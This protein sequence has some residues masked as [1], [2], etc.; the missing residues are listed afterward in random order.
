MRLLTG[1]SVIS[2]INSEYSDENLSIWSENRFYPCK[3]CK[4]P[5]NTDNPSLL[6]LPIMVITPLF[7]LLLFTCFP[8]SAQLPCDPELCPV[9]Y[10]GD[11]IC[12]LQC[13]TA[14]CGFDGLEAG[15]SDC[16]SDCVAVGCYK[17]L[18][19]ESNTCSEVCNVAECGF[20]TG[21]CGVCAPGCFEAILGDKDCQEVCNTVLC[22]YDQGDCVTFTQGN[23]SSGCFTSMLG[24]GHCDS[25]CLNSAC[26]FDNGDCSSQA[27]APDCYFHLLG[28]GV[29]QQQ[30]W[31]SACNYDYFDCAC[32]PGCAVVSDNTTCNPLCDTKDCGFDGGD[33]VCHM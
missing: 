11:G 3:P 20:D 18:G 12:D 19:E 32:S 21:A 9:S 1:L 33:C 14:G 8:V 17:T 29:C 10:R 31:V 7:S 27:C 16:E 28:D 26:N 30:C 15:T 5:H 4:K 24:D 13:M 23:C 2:N 6:I 25:F 22:A